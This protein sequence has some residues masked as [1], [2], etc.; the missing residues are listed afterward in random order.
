MNRGIIFNLQKYCVHDGPGIRTT[1]F[2]KGCPLNCWWCHNPESQLMKSEVMFWKDRCKFC[3]NC[4]HRC[5]AGAIDSVDKLLITNKGKCILCGKCSEFC[6]NNAREIIGKE[7]SV[8]ELMKEIDKDFVFYE[9]SGGGVTFSGG[10]PLSQID[11][12]SDMLKECKKNDIHTSVDTSGYAPWKNFEKILDKVDLFLF[13]IKHMD[14]EVHEKYTGVPNKLILDNVKK[15]S[16]LRKNI[17]IRI[18]I[19]PDINDDEENLV[20]TAKFLSNLNIIQI[21]LLP[22]HNIGMDKYKRSKKE[23]K[24]LDIQE[25]SKERMNEILEVFKDLGISVK[26]GG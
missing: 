21:N 7:I 11:F 6:F 24:L 26:I 8:N 15:L 17:Y 2:L 25:P 16:D 12:L 18:P 5:P 4:V 1:V 22:Y 3:G 13:D 23:Y 14:S 9:E 19:I 10:E 20:K